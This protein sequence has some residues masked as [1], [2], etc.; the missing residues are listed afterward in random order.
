M[1][2]QAILYEPG[3]GFHFVV[4]ES[5][6][7][8]ALCP[9]EAMLEQIDRLTSLAMLTNVRLGIIPFAKNYAVA[10]TH[11][12]SLHDERLVTV[13]TFSAELNLAQPQE[14]DLYRKVFD[15]MA[16]DADYDRKAR[17]HLN[18]AAE[19]VQQRIDAPEK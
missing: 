2:R 18:R 19:Q 3:R 10:P 17:A 12:F 9:P 15:S 1:A 14:I 4:T 7:L 11:G 6:L 16:L 13:E 5:V 8:L